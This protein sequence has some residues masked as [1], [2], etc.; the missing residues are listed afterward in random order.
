MSLNKKW[1]LIASIAITLILCY[2]PLCHRITS[3][4][5]QLWDESRNVTNAIE[6]L[7]NHK[8]FTRY[9]ENKPDTWEL[10][11]P[12][13]VWCQALSFKIFGFNELAARFPSMFFSMSTI[14]L[15]I[16]MGYKLSG[17]IGSGILASL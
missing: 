17:E 16:W 4:C 13:L 10:K 7:N 14:L 3:H 8:W 11:P 2:F 9:F 12:F 1:G 15:L 6:M 5:I